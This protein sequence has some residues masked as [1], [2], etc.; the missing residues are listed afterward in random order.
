MPSRAPSGSAQSSTSRRSSTTLT[1]L[2]APVR[3]KR[4]PQ[5]GAAFRVAFREGGS[6]SWDTPNKLARRQ[7][8]VKSE[9][10]RNAAMQFWAQAGLGQLDTMD[11]TLY[12]AIHLRICKALGPELTAAE[13]E[14]AG[15]EDWAEDAGGGD[16]LSFERYT[17][18]LAG[19]AD[20]WTTKID[21]LEAVVF[22][23]KLHQR[24]TVRVPE[25]K[26]GVSSSLRRNMYEKIGGQELSA[27][28]L[29]FEGSV[30]TG[31]A[32]RRLNH[33]PPFDSPDEFTAPAASFAAV[34]AGARLLGLAP[35]FALS[36][37]DAA[38]TRARTAAA[39]WTRL[40]AVDK[41]EVAAEEAAAEERERQLREA[42]A[43]FDVDG[44]GFLT[45]AEL[46]QVLQRPGGGKQMTD[47]QVQ[48]LFRKMDV[49]G[50]GK[51]DLDEFSK[52]LSSREA[53][54]LVAAMAP[55]MHLSQAEE[56]AQD[57]LMD[58]D[59]IAASALRRS[60]DTSLDTWLGPQGGLSE[61]AAARRSSFA[62]AS[63]TLLTAAGRDSAGDVPDAPSEVLQPPPV[64][65][66]LRWSRWGRIKD[67]TNQ[68]SGSRLSARASRQSTVSR[69]SARA[70]SV[71]S[72]SGTSP[73]SP[74][75]PPEGLR[76]RG[77]A[78]LLSL[79]AG[80][81]VHVAS[82]KRTS[83]FAAAPEASPTAA[84][85]STPE[86]APEA[87]ADEAEARE[88]ELATWTRLTLDEPPQADEAE[89]KEV[90][91]ATWTRLRLDK[92]PRGSRLAA[93][94]TFVVASSHL[95]ANRP[96]AVKMASGM[97]ANRPPAAALAV[98][99]HPRH[100]RAVA[101]LVDDGQRRVVEPL[102]QRSGAHHAA[103]VGRNNLQVG[104]IASLYIA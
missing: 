44:D 24:V 29:P 42:F 7:Q 49:D 76:R 64:T 9:K 94:P 72:S 90:E 19:L 67:A 81:L 68:S 96:P 97:R 26:N 92:P 54:Q 104:I 15:A 16:S 8:L 79:A 33:I 82:R 66:G 4:V 48:Q 36:E 11:M 35:A 57:D 6:P 73:S 10:L 71:F 27:S 103:D 85:V 61:V 39:A 63:V 87:E 22:L 77:V 84:A 91:L 45:L 55:E 37:A 32:W 74:R 2:Q 18:G 78:G 56:E 102:G 75:R 31:R 20:Q 89:A 69:L 50:D 1:Q 59:D 41:E 17:R 25:D 60:S 70:S 80:R 38:E 101:A 88:V 40:V 30:D 28:A 86:P 65:V 51:V 83:S 95:G 93:A 58:D 3:V 47:A 14:E 43:K 99:H 23:N 13:A 62:E 100:A 52:T 12:L 21:E 5:R 46:R 53:E 34:S 98:K